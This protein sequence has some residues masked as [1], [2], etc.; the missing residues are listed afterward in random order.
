MNTRLNF[1][2]DP[3]HRLASGIVFA[4]RHYWETRKVGST[5]CAARRCS[6]GQASP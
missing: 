1:G 5:D 3:G 2:S 6:A 4:I